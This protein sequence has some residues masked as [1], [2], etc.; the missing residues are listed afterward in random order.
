[1]KQR[2]NRFSYGI[3]ARAVAD[4]MEGKWMRNDTLS[5]IEKVVG[6]PRHEI[7]LSDKREYKG[8]KA[9]AL[10]GM[11]LYMQGVCEDLFRGIEPEL[12]PVQVRKRPDGMSGKVRDIAL[13]SVEHQLL[14]HIAKEMLMPFFRAKLLPQQHAS[15]PGHGQTRLR[16]QLHK[17]LLSDAGIKAYSKTDVCQAYKSTQYSV[18]IALIEEELPK[19]KELHI[20][21]RFLGKMAPDGHLIIGGYLDAWL[22]NLV[23]SY[24][25]RYT[26]SQGKMRRGKFIPYLIT[27]QNYMDDV[28]ELSGSVT[29]LM[30][31]ERLM[32]AYLR[33]RFS[34]RLKIVKEPVRLLTVSQERIKRK[35]PKKSQRGCPGI[36]MAGFV[37][38]RTYVTIRPKIFIKARRQFLRAW[39][40]YEKTGTIP[41]AR[42]HKIEAYKGYFIDKNGEPVTDSIYA[43]KKYHIRELAAISGRVIAY[44]DRDSARVREVRKNDYRKCIINYCSAAGRNGSAAGYPSAYPFIKGCRGDRNRRGNILQLQESRVLSA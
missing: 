10:L 43:I 11:A 28:A 3:C 37:V 6:I 40:E 34:L 19:A 9:E 32:D 44:H 2:F 14:E 36:D 30:K 13:L 35:L 29:S 33:E 41:I 42:A 4:Y 27:V 20:L 22:F 7:I 31:A 15:I 16:D 18:V 39:A 25:L 1:M 17:Y 23:M 12:E 21:L 38:H 5:F 8:V 26:L 24:A